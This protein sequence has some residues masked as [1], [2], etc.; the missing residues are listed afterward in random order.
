MATRPGRVARLVPNRGKL[1]SERELGAWRSGRRR[2]IFS[3]YTNRGFARGA[4]SREETGRAAAAPVGALAASEPGAPAGRTAV[5][6]AR[7]DGDRPLRPGRGSRL[8]VGG[9]P[10]G[11]RRGDRAEGGGGA[12]RKSVV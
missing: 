3:A 2:A 10:A 9:G 11:T 4:K 5:R 6:P 1:P 7:H 12:D 8:R